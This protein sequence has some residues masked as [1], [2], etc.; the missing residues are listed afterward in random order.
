MKTNLVIPGTL[1]SLKAFTKTHN[2]QEQELN[3]SLLEE[4]RGATKTIGFS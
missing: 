3:Q 1:V 2:E 4:T